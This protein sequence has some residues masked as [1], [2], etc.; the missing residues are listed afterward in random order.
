MIF[1]GIRKIEKPPGLLTWDGILDNSMAAKT[2]EKH[3]I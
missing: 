3:F 1:L 2:C